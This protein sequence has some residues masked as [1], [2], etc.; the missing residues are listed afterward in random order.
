[1]IR[2]A[3]EPSG[4]TAQ[5]AAVAGSVAVW[6]CQ[7]TKSTTPLSGV[8]IG[9]SSV[10]PGASAISDPQAVHET[11][12]GHDVTIVK[13][14]DDWVTLAW[15]QGDVFLRLTN[16]YALSPTTS[17]FGPS[18]HPHFTPDQLRQIVASVR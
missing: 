3:C 4:R 10:Q 2:A 18:S 16:P 1:M 14:G 12:E 7:R 8:Q 5:S 9:A 15:V 11:I 17:P 6:L 13:R